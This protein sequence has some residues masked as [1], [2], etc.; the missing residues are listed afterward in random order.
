MKA[1]VQKV[2][3]H[4]TAAEVARSPAVHTYSRMEKMILLWEKQEDYMEL[5][6]LQPE[7]EHPLMMGY[8]LLMVAGFVVADHS[9][10]MGCIL[11]VVTDHSMMS[12]YTLLVVAGFVVADHSMMVG[13][14]LLIAPGLSSMSGYTLL[15]V[16]DHPLT[17][18]YSCPD[19][20][21]EAMAER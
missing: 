7:S 21:M 20:S 8:I 1:G 18:D 15:M 12:G 13:Y 14:T 19:Y 2:L 5:P 9:T 6:P 3:R 16:A 11:L 4:Q 10:M 17:A